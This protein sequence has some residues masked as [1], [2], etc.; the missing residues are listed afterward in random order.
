MRC[1]PVVP[2]IPRT[3]SAIAPG[4]PA[5]LRCGAAGVALGLALG[6]A[7]AVPAIAQAFS[8]DDVAAKAE[9]LARE[10]YLD[11]R[12][13]PP[14]WLLAGSM[15]YDAWRDIRF[16]PERSLWRS[17]GLP[18]QVQFFHPG[19]WYNR[20]ISVDTVDG[21]VVR[22]VP[23]DIHSFDYG[24]NDFGSRIPADIGW[25]GFRIHAP[26]RTK[27]YYDELVVFLGATYFRALGRDN[28]YG[29][30][31]RGI[32]L[33]T[34]DPGG[35][36]F[37]HFVE[38]WI[39]KPAKGATSIV[40]YALMEGPSITGA[41]R[42]DVQP[43]TSTAIDVDSR[44]FPRREIKKLGIAPLTSM[45][46]FGEN[47]RTRY[48]DFRPEVHDSDGLLAH[49]ESGEWLWRP[50]DNPKTIS[51]SI[52]GMDHPRGFGL[53]QRDHAFASYQDLE[54]H[55]ERRP[56]AWVE[57]K[58]DWGPGHVE[59]D[60]IPT[61]NEL[62]DN[63]VAYWVPDAPPTPG[64]SLNFAYTV[65]FFTDDPALAPGGRVLSTRQDGGVHGDRNRFVIEFGGGQLNAIAD[66]NPPVAMIT[67]SPADAAE[68]LDQHVV[69]NP[70]T[71][72]WRLAFQL[73]SKIDAPIE[74]RAFLKGDGKAL[75]ETWSTAVLR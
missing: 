69:R 38:F 62:V 35:E 14:L 68:L 52:F 42:F 49:F 31:A 53:L 12:E 73:E 39:E 30:S 43:G 33:N 72:G 57:P 4:L 75:T 6:L 48:D 45:F 64:H 13:S 65:S 37:P 50:L 70:D 47:S 1:F 8:L 59:L 18:F 29:I 20:S 7:L 19:I 17:E 55:A 61:S 15:S 21:G 3:V 5:P 10:E 44:L 32:A 54:T 58:G 11:H 36:E 34:V 74:L 28:V 26:L 66:A 40:V 25:A 63:V 60:Q 67:T 16:N 41:Y 24:K 2:T 71:G 27:D 46:W 23:F 22:P 56:G 51:A 9:T